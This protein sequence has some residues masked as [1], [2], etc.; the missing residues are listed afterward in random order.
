MFYY[1]EEYKLRGVAA[2]HVEDMISTGDQIFYEDVIK[3][4]MEAVTFG[5]TSEGAYKCLGWNIRH[6]GGAFL[7]SQF[8]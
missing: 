8:D 3:P 6:E 4:L 5:S 1:T 2:W 7:V